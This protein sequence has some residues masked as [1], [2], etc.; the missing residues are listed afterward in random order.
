M[1]IVV[2]FDISSQT[3][4]IIWGSLPSAIFDKCFQFDR[5][6]TWN[7]QNIKLF[8]IDFDSISC[9]IL[10]KYMLYKL[11]SSEGKGVNIFHF[12]WDFFRLF[13]MY[14]K[15][16]A[17]LNCFSVD[18]IFRHFG[19]RRWATSNFAST[20]KRRHSCCRRLDS[21]SFR[22]LVQVWTFFRKERKMYMGPK[23][24]Q[25]KSNSRSA[26]RP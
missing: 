7:Y 16:K 8:G 22:H 15:K 1:I 10:M 5:L 11:N 18:R 14:L 25:Y 6:F 2:D 23:N 26:N 24:Y 20:P 13:N 9:R 4:Q 17:F 21:L 12:E 19:L 3:S